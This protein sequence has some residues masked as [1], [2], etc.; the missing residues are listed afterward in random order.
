MT[1]IGTWITQLVGLVFF[2][3]VAV[4]TV[5]VTWA[6]TLDYIDSR[7]QAKR[8]REIVDSLAMVHRWF[9]GF[10]DLDIIWNYVYGKRS[11]SIDSV[12]YDYAKARGTDVYGK[13]KNVSEQGK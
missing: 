8:D 12:R 2:V 11:G 4:I 6:V 3:A 5:S 7:S 1:E 9:S 13:P 10:R